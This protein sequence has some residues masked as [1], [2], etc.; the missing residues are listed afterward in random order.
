MLLPKKK[1]STWKVTGLTK[2]KAAVDHLHFIPFH[3]HVQPVKN[4]TMMN[5]TKN[6]TEKLDFYLYFCGNVLNTMSK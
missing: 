2:K 1:N 6:K 5:L 4:L 3:A